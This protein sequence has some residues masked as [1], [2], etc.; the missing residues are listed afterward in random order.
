MPLSAT[1]RGPVAGIQVL[2]GSLTGLYAFTAFFAVLA[3]TLERFGIAIGFT[4]A[5]AVAL[6]IQASSLAALRR[7]A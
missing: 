2:C 6:A 3:V 1:K 4:T 5:T 7:R